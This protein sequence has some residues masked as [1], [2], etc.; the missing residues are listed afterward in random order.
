LGQPRKSHWREHAVERTFITTTCSKTHYRLR[1]G[2]PTDEHELAS[3]FSGLAMN[4]SIQTLK[5]EEIE[6]NDDLIELMAP[7]LADNHVFKC[8]EV[9]VN[10]LNK[11][12][13]IT[14]FLASFLLMFDYL[15]EFRLSYEGYNDDL[16]GVDEGRGMR[17]IVDYFDIVIQA[18]TVHTELMQLTFNNIDI[19]RRGCDSLVKLLNNCTNLKEL[20]FSNMGMINDGWQDIFTALQNTKCKLEKIEL[21]GVE[22]A[23][24]VTALCLSHALLHHST[25]LKS[26]HLN[27]QVRVVIPSVIIPLL[28]DPKSILEE[29]SLVNDNAANDAYSVTNE[30]IEVLTNALAVNRRL[31][32][33]VLTGHRSITAEGWMIF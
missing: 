19:R 29:L 11:E 14:T 20:H 8:L 24:E 32:S 27:Q 17:T 30:G 23:N 1:H 22:G 25:T 28:Q 6:L 10:D 9:V 3:F 16:D 31:K 4:R 21:R 26:L 2:L 15:T 12:D 13:Y 7:F 33:L 5:F 18:L